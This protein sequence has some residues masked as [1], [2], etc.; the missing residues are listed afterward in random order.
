[1]IFLDNHTVLAAFSWKSFD[2]QARRHDKKN[3]T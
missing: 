2:I 1:M 3:K